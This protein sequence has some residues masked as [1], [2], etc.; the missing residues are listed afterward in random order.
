MS[1]ERCDVSEPGQHDQEPATAGLSPA[2][3]PCA[4]P[5]VDTM[6]LPPE[7]AAGVCS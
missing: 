4:V 7:P 2:H 6:S 5:A 1:C 3:R